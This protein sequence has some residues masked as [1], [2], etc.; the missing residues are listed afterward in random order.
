[1]SKQTINNNNHTNSYL[2]NTNVNNN[3]TDEEYQ[4][5]IMISFFKIILSIFIFITLISIKYLKIYNY[6]FNE[7]NNKNITFFNCFTGG[8]FFYISFFYASNKTFYNIY[9]KD[10]SFLNNINN[11]EIISFFIGFIIIFFIRK[12]LYKSISFFI[13]LNITKDI[14]KHEVINEIKK[15]FKNININNNIISEI[16]ESR[17]LSFNMTENMFKNNTNSF[18]QKYKKYNNI[19]MNIIEKNENEYELKKEKIKKEDSFNK[20]N[21]NNNS[22]DNNLIINK[23]FK[24][25]D[26]DEETNEEFFLSVQEKQNKKINKRKPFIKNK[27]ILNSQIPKFNLNATKVKKNEKV[28]EDNIHKIGTKINKE[29]FDIVNKSEKDIDNKSITINLC[30]E[31]LFILIIKILIYNIHILLIG[32]FIGFL[33]LKGNI[34]IF[35]FLI[36][37]TL[38]R[39]LYDK[40]IIMYNNDIFKNEPIIQK[41]ILIILDLIYP[42][43]IIIGNH[44]FN[45]YYKQY[46]LSTYYNNII[47]ILKGIC[48][49]AFLFYGIFLLYFE[50]TKNNIDIQNKFLFFSFGIILSFI[51]V[52]INY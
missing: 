10:L 27:K 52:Y 22:N 1:M 24:D 41:I 20:K 51:I 29:V 23:P 37:L 3:L 16:Y 15:N 32:I 30:N 50:E 44:L 39:V 19:E 49:G 13:P 48:S 33:N 38:F 36:L 12:I 7:H 25:A 43:G 17:Q 6:L 18:N 34:M 42:I 11:L 35:I 31:K 46:Y 8:F 28:K 45:I 26:N 21:T 47:I 40:N 14:S 9:H 5:L 2:N 4:Y